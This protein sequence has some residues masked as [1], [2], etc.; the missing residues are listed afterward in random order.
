MRNLSTVAV[1]ALL[2]IAS[3]VAQEPNAEMFARYRAH[4]IERLDGSQFMGR[5]LNANLSRLFGVPSDIRII[6]TAE[7]A[8]PDQH[9]ITLI[10][11]PIRQMC[12]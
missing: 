7:M 9:R 1:L 4:A 5:P 3:T 10:F 12:F 11:L 8:F 2:Q 6:N